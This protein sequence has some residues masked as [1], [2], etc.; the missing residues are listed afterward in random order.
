MLILKPLTKKFIQQYALSPSLNF[1][2][3]DGSPY[4]S[5]RSVQLEQ[6]I[7]K[8]ILTQFEDILLYLDILSWRKGPMVELLKGVTYCKVSPMKGNPILPGGSGFSPFPWQPSLCL[9]R[10][11]EKIQTKL[12]KQLRIL[13]VL[14]PTCLLRSWLC[15]ILDFSLLLSN[16]Q[17]YDLCL[18]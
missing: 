2:C 3:I 13:L 1:I 18:C 15:D 14:L 4:R 9:Y 10:K 5:C 8:N 11:V 12:Q 7:L 17:S 6:E 16:N